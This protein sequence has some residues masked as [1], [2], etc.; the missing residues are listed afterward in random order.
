MEFEGRRVQFG[1]RLRP[2]DKEVFSAAA[3]RCG[4]DPSGAAR[5][6]IELVVQRLEAGGD[7]L[8]ALHELKT[9]WG[10]PRK[11]PIELRLA[12]LNRALVHFSSTQDPSALETKIEAVEQELLQHANDDAPHVKSEGAG[13]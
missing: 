11:S 7:L 1:M 2:H 10:V 3:E 8:D 6:I 5:Q 12:A 9:A 13:G 4:I